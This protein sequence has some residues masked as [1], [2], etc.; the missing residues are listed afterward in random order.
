MKITNLD[1]GKAYQLGEAAKLEVER[2]NPFFNDY[3]ETTS[4]LDIPASDYNCER[5]RGL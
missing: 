4:P 5:E 2:T 1:K 3:G